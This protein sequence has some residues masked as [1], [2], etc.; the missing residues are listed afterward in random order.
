[1]V[2]DRAMLP[3]IF[4][5]STVSPGAVMLARCTQR[6]CDADP[7]RWV[8]SQ[9]T[10]SGAGYVTAGKAPDGRTF[11]TAEVGGALFVGV[12]GNVG[13]DISPLF[14]CAGVAAQGRIPP[15]S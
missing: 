12:E 4:Y 3:R 2:I 10:S 6:P 13:Y 9:Q 11:F 7:S 14:G 15:P 5:S 1:M 8:V